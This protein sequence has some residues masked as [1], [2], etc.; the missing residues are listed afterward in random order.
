MYRVPPDRAWYF[1]VGAPLERRVRPRTRGTLYLV[2]CRDE[3]ELRVNRE[4][5]MHWAAEQVTDAMAACGWRVTR[6]S[7]PRQSVTAD[8]VKRVNWKAD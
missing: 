4:H 2:R 5:A 7:L 6:L 3:D 8:A 1:A